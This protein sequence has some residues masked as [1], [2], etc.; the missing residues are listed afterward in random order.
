MDKKEFL[1]EIGVKTTK[2]IQNN[3]K[4]R[5]VIDYIEE[6]DISYFSTGNYIDPD[7]F[8]YFIENMKSA[9]KIISVLNKEAYLS[10]F[11]YD[12]KDLVKFFNLYNPDKIDMIGGS[13]VL[14][15]SEYLKYTTIEWTENVLSKSE[16]IIKL[17][18]DRVTF[19]ENP[20]RPGELEYI[21]AFE[22]NVRTL[23][24]AKKEGR[25]LEVLKRATNVMG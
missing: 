21:S 3:P 11:N 7:K 4:I 23:A 18:K 13:M 6:N 24:L 9:D 1:L 12:Y 8:L 16:F 10:N 25:L 15:D 2:D 17:N 20:Y 14:T 19:E 22:H 5:Q